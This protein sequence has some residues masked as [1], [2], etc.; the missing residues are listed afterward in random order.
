M[1]GKTN[2]TECINHVIYSWCRHDGYSSQS[3][4]I[5]SDGGGQ[6]VK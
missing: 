4:G 5:C 6:E 2:L 1:V 3:T